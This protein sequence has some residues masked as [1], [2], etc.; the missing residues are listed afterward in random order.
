VP[1]GRYLVYPSSA[2][3]DLRWLRDGRECVLREPPDRRG[4]SRD[5]PPEVLV[6][7]HLDGVRPGAWREGD[8]VEPL[9]Q[10]CPVTLRKLAP[11][12]SEWGGYGD[13][14]GL[15]GATLFEVAVRHRGDFTSSQAALN[16]SE[17]G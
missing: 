13:W 1:R 17:S 4:T 7:D 10:D 15:R 16:G 14:M 8:L 11:S 12:S 3:R 2:D 9:E 6:T 5:A